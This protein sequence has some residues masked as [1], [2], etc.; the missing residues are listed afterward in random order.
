[1][2]SDIDKIYEL[3]RENSDKSRQREDTKNEA[4]RLRHE[5][6][7]I[8]IAEIKSHIKTCPS[9]Q[10]ISAIENEFKK[11]LTDE[12]WYSIAKE[13]LRLIGAAVAGLLSGSLWHK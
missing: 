4:D 2:T 10:R 3:I 5:S 8:E 1:M 11:H 12:K 13:F 6:L 9:N 7:L